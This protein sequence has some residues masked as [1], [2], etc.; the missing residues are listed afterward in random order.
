MGAE[1]TAVIGATLGLGRVS[2]VVAALGPAAARGRGVVD[3]AG[4][5]A[6]AASPSPPAREAP[7]V[8]RA[9]I[10]RSVTSTL[11]PR[12]DNS[13]NAP[14][15]TICLRSRFRRESSDKYTALGSWSGGG[16]SAAASSC[17]L[18]ML[19]SSAVMASGP[20]PHNVAAAGPEISVVHI[21]RTSGVKTVISPSLSPAVTP[22]Q[23]VGVRRVERRAP[24]T[25][26]TRH[27]PAA[28]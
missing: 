11:H 12:V 9:S 23:G 25:P 28:I 20:A 10:I 4:L 8:S 2:A 18:R 16:A 14:I 24:F 17:T 3:G 1:R 13:P 27:P 19:Q 26:D 5:G 21:Y 7:V 22:Q 6:D 15:R